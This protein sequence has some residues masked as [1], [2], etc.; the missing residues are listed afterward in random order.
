MLIKKRLKIIKR[1][2]K[3]LRDNLICDKYLT[4]KK[5]NI[6]DKIYRI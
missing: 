5:R 4:E 3:K 1:I 6:F 2:I